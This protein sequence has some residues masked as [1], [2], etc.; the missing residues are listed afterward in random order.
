[1]LVAGLA[2]VALAAACSDNTN[3]NAN[4]NGNTGISTNSNSRAAVNL[5]TN[6]T[7]ST[8]ANTKR[9]PTR[10]D[11]NA[12]KA[13]YEA[14]AKK[15]GSKVGTGAN[16]MWLWVKTRYDLAAADDLRDSSI[17]VDV[18]N[19][20]ITLN[21]DVASQA[22]VAKADQIAKAVE[23]QKGVKNKLKVAAGGSNANSGS[24]NRNAPAKKG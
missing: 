3:S 21:G 11:V 7:A 15:G 22:Q 17:N 23:G 20:V 18:D 14:E 6:T 13:T 1:M 12:N 9:S 24:A 4:G 5:N 19:G 10:E 2:L 8:N 16:D